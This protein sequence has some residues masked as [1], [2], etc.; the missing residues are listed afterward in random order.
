MARPLLT[1]FLALVFV[2]SGLLPAAAATCDAKFVV[3]EV[4]LPASS[5][6]T[7][8]QQSTLRGGLIGRCFSGSKPGELSTWEHAA[9]ANL[10]YFDATVSEPTVRI[11][12]SSRHPQPV[13][14]NLEFIEGARYRI[15]DITWSGIQAI[16]NERIVSISELHPGDIL[17]YSKVHEMLDTVR[18]LYHAIGYW[19]VEITLEIQRLKEGQAIVNYKVSEGAWYP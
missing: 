18:M 19:D 8:R 6:L 12:D 9:L 10:G 2:I 13:A 17:N 1:I 5:Q 4:N 11:V 16:S 15:R 3:T 7:S 14:L